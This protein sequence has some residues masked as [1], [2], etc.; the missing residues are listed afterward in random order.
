MEGRN[1]CPSVYLS[2]H[3]SIHSSIIPCIYVSIYLT[4]SLEL[5]KVRFQFRFVEQRGCLL[6][7]GIFLSP[8]PFDHTGL[9]TT[10]FHRPLLRAK[11]PFSTVFL[12]PFGL[13]PLLLSFVHPEKVIYKKTSAECMLC[14]GDIP[15][16]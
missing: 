4:G 10:K 3:P 9:C 2:I 6:I 16:R 1:F 12:F 11:F 14:G 7:C 8:V 15:R 13:L 5:K